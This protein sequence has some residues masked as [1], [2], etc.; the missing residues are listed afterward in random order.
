MAVAREKPT[1][2]E[3]DKEIVKRAF[4]NCTDV[5]EIRLWVDRMSA[6]DIAFVLLFIS[7]Q[8]DFE[9]L[10]CQIGDIFGDIPVVGCSTA[11]EISD[12]GYDDGKIIALA[13]PKSHFSAKLHLVQSLK[14]VQYGQLQESLTIERSALSKSHPD[15]PHE[16]HFLMIDG[17]SLAED[18]FVAGV[19]ASTQNV[20]LFGGSSGDGTAFEKTRI[21]F[22]GHLY[23]D[24]AV[25]LQVRTR[26][27]V[28]IFKTDHLSATDRRMVVTK[29]QPHLR[30]VSEINGAPAAREYARVL[31]KDPDQLTPFT[32]AAHPVV[33]TIGDQ[34]FVR[35]IQRVSQEGELIFFS[36]ID[37]GLVLSLADAHD[38]A[39]HLNDTL[40]S[41]SERAHPDII[42]ACDCILRRLEAEEK[43][44]SLELSQLMKAHKL[45][46]FSTYGEQ[47]QSMHINQTLTGVAI[48]PPEVS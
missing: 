26:C 48:Y 47:F 40:Q 22:Q 44:K 1:L 9:T 6:E 13:F 11:G 45:V 43:Q 20:P 33:V 29:A 18:I 32:F 38:L 36:A 3:P 35:A 31:G 10:S 14:T 7:P 8:S 25:I 24:A 16:F 15:W 34:H 21:L 2:K 23:N 5:H 39:E 41:L 30:T 28:R 42:V 19:F 4:V 12:N 37:E 17:L 46:G 27:R